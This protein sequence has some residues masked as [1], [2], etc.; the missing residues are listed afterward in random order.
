MGPLGRCDGPKRLARR[1]WGARAL[2][3]APEAEMSKRT[4][5]E[6]V[7]ETECNRCDQVVDSEP[8]DAS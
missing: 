5:Q 4:I 8:F 1:Q 2:P 7:T 6:E 3:P